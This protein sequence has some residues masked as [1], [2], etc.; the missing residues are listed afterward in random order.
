MSA[1]P[2]PN[3][4]QNSL[5]QE[6]VNNNTLAEYTR[7]AQ[8]KQ[9]TALLAQQ[10]QAVQQ[11]NQATQA[12][13][14]A[15]QGA[16]K[17]DPNTGQMTLDTDG[18]QQALAA[19]GHGAAIPAVIK[20]IT[21]YQTSKAQLQ[22]QQQKLQ[23]GS[24]DAMGSL[25]FA[26]QQ[27][28]YDP[29]LAH[30]IIQDHMNDPTLT[31]QARQQLQAEQ[32][33][34]SQNPALIKQIA[35]QWVSQS[36]AQQQKEIERQNAES[37]TMKDRYK[38]VNGSLYDVSGDQPKLITPQGADPDAYVKLVDQVVPPK[39]PNAGLNARTKAAVQFY[40]QQG[41]VKAA[42]D[43]IKTA[44]QQVGSIEKDIQIQT[45]PQIQAGK[46]E[47]AK[48]TAVAR[49]QAQAGNFGQAGD[50]MIDMV[51]QN[52]VDLGT[53]LQRI[54]PAQKDLFLQNLAA[55]YPE[56]N[57]G[58]FGVA[59]K[60]QTAYTSGSQG[61][62]LTAIDTA[63]QHMQTFKQTADALDNGDF[64]LA[65]KLGNAIGVQFGADKATNFNVARSAFAGEVG[66]A[67]AGANVGVSDRQE[68]IDKINAASSPAQL[69]GYADT[70]DKLLEGKQVALKRSYDQGVQGK[71]NFGGGGMVTMK[72]PNGATKQVPSDQVDHYK[73]LGASVVSQ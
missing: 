64:L 49:Q 34:I 33:E 31:P 42:Q 73:S 40:V 72:A 16:F 4:A 41:N 59:K 19:N 7:A 44:G 10:T 9:Q 50:P 3:I 66:K 55:K 62:Q 52:R 11:Q 26:L 29:Q 32:Q 43:E 63:R 65:N 57:Q 47:V 51:G 15:Y 56:Y 45:N 23:T 68:L 27:A 21:D 1:I 18:L 39:G 5:E 2:A 8:E 35:D 14:Q 61:Q 17:K 54:P 36:P 22:E 37:N 70:A 53:V 24:A 71:A 48:N 28:N 46:V 6:Q 67:F 20:G 25:G 13:N 38:E 12:V 60:E 58:T 30:T 69:K